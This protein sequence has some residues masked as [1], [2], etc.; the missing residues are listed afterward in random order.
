MNPQAAA[1]PAAG[2]TAAV[3]ASAVASGGMLAPADVAQVLGV[4]ETDVM[5]IIESGELKS[6]KIGAS[7]R[8]TKAALD[9]YLAQ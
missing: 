4:P 2:A 8:I 5:A 9:A 1:A 6:K 7:Y 3:A